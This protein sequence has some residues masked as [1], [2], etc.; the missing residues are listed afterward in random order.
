MQTAILEL[1]RLENL[2]RPFPS[3]WRGPE[4]V[5]QARTRHLRR[6]I[7]G[8]ACGWNTGEPALQLTIQVNMDGTFRR[9]N[10]MIL[11][12]IDDRSAVL[13]IEHD[14]TGTNALQP[15][16]PTQIFSQLN[17]LLVILHLGAD[18][19]CDNHRVIDLPDVYPI[20]IRIFASLF[21][22]AMT[23]HLSPR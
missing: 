20:L 22:S 16:L 12:V 8:I 7:G 1:T 15:L 13:A 17:D 4:F 10:R 5:K 18:A 21:Q 11:Q 23:E 19:R 6:F 9:F 3:G 14:R 2:Q